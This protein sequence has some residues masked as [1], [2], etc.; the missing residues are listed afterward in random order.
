MAAVPQTNLLPPGRAD[1]PEGTV[2]NPGAPAGYIDAKKF[3]RITRSIS[4]INKNLSG[5][6][7]L[8][9]QDLVQDQQAQV[10]EDKRK[11]QRVDNIKKDKK[12]NFIEGAIQNTITKPVQKMAKKAKSAFGGFFKALTMIFAG[13]LL[14]KGGDALRAFAAGDTKTL[15][16]IRDN[17]LKAFGVAGGIFLL[18]NGGIPLIFSAVSALIGT[19][20][21]TIPAILALLANPA[22]WIA[23]GILGA[24]IA[25]T[26]FLSNEDNYKNDSS[27]TIEE[28]VRKEGIAET[29]A[30]LQQELD[31]KTKRRSE[32]NV[33]NPLQWGEYISLGT[34]LAEIKEQMKAVEQG[35]TSKDDPNYRA[36]L[37]P[38]KSVASDIAGMLGAKTFEEPISQ[39]QR[40]AFAQ[41]AVISKQLAENMK[42]QEALNQ[43]ISTT[44]G[45]GKKT[46]LKAQLKLLKEEQLTIMNDAKDK[47]D[48]DTLTDA[49][50][51]LLM[52]IAQKAFEEV[53][54]RPMS[55]G[56]AESSAS[57]FRQ[58]EMLEQ[59]SQHGLE[60]PPRPDPNPAPS[61]N[62]Q[63]IPVVPY[64]PD[65][66]SLEATLAREDA[67][68]NKAL[69]KENMPP[70]SSP[71][72]NSLDLVKQPF[73]KES[74]VTLVPFDYQKDASGYEGDENYREG[75]ASGIPD[76]MTSNPD[77]AYL[78][79]FRSVYGIG[80]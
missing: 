17:V 37:P 39:E 26:A 10:Q 34:E 2:V 6:T 4:N 50:K 9:Q 56:D 25:L 22:V 53:E 60:A 5:I 78:L 73:K 46:S 52:S 69:E 72:N 16:S 49:Q 30:K 74:K 36:G 32:L 15:E 59:V 19:I 14:D 31:E 12:E 55:L 11:K 23:A 8:L 75:E 42:K 67:A 68:L 41:M 33:F 3:G 54:G 29:L 64:D 65:D 77:N 24:G 47:V 1:T 51:A 18:L 43:Q 13:W 44:Q 21:T 20:I 76:L 7:S 80:K 45:K 48:S 35:Y 66:K 28:S 63:S 40:A 61:N 71:Q 57:L 79:H 58:G 38:A 27:K 62:A 70:I